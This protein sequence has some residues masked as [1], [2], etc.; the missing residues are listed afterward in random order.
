MN[1]GGTRREGAGLGARRGGVN[2]GVAE[3]CVEIVMAFELLGGK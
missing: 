2:D 1:S 3:G